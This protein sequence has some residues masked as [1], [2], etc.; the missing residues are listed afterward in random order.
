MFDAHVKIGYFLLVQ[1]SDGKNI[2]IYTTDPTVS[3][4]SC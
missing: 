3:Q 4:V 1:K 2:E